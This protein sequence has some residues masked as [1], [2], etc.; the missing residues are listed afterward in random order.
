M[1]F[2]KNVNTF[3]NLLSFLRKPISNLNDTEG[4]IYKIFVDIEKR[5]N[6]V[7]KHIKVG[8][9]LPF[10]LLKDF[11]N[12]VYG[13]RFMTNLFNGDSFKIKNNLNTLYNVIDDYVTKIE[14]YKVKS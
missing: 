14:N 4:N 12:E 6:E 1:Y 5:A 11:Y 7:Y 2:S 3:Y 13:I 8:E 9:R 10:G